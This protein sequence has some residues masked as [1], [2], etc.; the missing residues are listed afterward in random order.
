MSNTASSKPEFMIYPEDIK[1]S[2]SNP[3]EGQKITLTTTVFNYG[4]VGMINVPVDLYVDS[5]KVSSAI[6]SFIPALANQT[7]EFCWTATAG[8]HNI[9]IIANEA[10]TIPESD[11]GNN[12]A[13]KSITVV[14]GASNIAVTN[15]ILPKNVI[16]QGYNMS[17]N[18]TVVNKGDFT[19]TFNVTI[20]ANTTILELQTV[21]LSKGTSTTITF[22]W[23][24]MGFAFGDYTI[25]AYAWPILGETDIDD[26]TF[27]DGWVIVS[28]PGDINGDGVVDSTDQGILGM[29]WGSIIG[30]PNYVPEADLNG[31]GVVDSIDLG[32]V[33]VNWGLSWL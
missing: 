27:V 5:A 25:S 24:T 6:V 7:I 33:G 3:R 15:I 14:A 8:T 4:T 13:R 22:T 19:E 21:T 11:Y 29:A 32:V 2:D 26:N 10:Q 18:V 16:G 9:T 1:L 20:Y 30:E 12:Q 23:N 28:I 17:I 31:D